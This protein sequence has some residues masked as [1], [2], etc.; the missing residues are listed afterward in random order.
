MTPIQR[1]TSRMSAEELQRVYNAAT[2]EEKA[3]LEMSLRMKDIRH[4][5]HYA[6]QAQAAQ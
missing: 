2:P 3:Q 4:R 6:P 5:S 1:L